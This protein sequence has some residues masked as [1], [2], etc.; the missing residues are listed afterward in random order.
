MASYVP[1][2]D[3]DV[4]AR[5]PGHWSREAKKTGCAMLDIRMWPSCI[6]RPPLWPTWSAQVAAQKTPEV[7][8]PPIRQTVTVT[9]ESFSS[10]QVRSLIDYINGTN[11]GDWKVKL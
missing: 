10:D 9:G 11:S 7:G 6:V 1:I 5:D 8:P 3:S 2:E 4:L